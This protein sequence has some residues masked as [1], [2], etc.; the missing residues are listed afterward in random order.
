MLDF[1]TCEW[2]ETILT[3]LDSC[4]GISSN[5]GIKNLLPTLADFDGDSAQGSISSLL[6]NGIPSRCKNG[7][8]NPY[9]ERWPELRGI[10]STA[11]SYS[12]DEVE[13][14]HCRLF[15]GVGD[16]AAA[17]CGSKC[18]AYSTCEYGSHRIAVTIGTSAAARVCL[19]L[20]K[21]PSDSVTTV[22]HGLFCYRVDKS[23]I[24]VG[25]ALTDG[26]SAIEWARK[27]LNLQFADAFDAALEEVSNRYCHN[28]G[29]PSLECS[30]SQSIGAAVTMIPFLSGERSTGFRGAATGCISGITR[31][32]TPIDILLGCFEGVTLRLC[33]VIGLIEEVC[34]N[35]R[36]HETSDGS[37]DA[38]QAILVVSGNALEK[39]TLWRQMIA[40]CSG[41]SVVVDGESNEG[42]SRGVAMLISR[43]IMQTDQSAEV[44]SI[45]S[46]SHPVEEANSRWAT[47]RLTQDDLINA[48]SN[49]WGR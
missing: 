46:I 34:H 24:L 1:A 17:N 36:K 21:M 42:T 35:Q 33:A 23:R 5:G 6:S 29:K 10:E 45:A 41:L 27:L 11:D 48:V 40:D 37:D 26:G 31:D 9:W 38:N 2:N 22:P 8:F 15:L 4:K 7:E 39:N 14:Q 32:T 30:C 20:Q 3:I 44:L 18:D 47:V 28:F 49:T 16:G 19:P 25:G 43:R 12:S 13:A